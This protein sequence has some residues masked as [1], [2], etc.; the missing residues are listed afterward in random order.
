M[1]EA[2]K[3]GVFIWWNGTVKWNGEMEQWNGIVE[4]NGGIVE[5]PRPSSAFCDPLPFIKDKGLG[6]QDTTVF[7]NH[8]RPVVLA[9]LKEAEL[10]MILQE[11]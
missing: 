5:R 10:K 6:N 9:V 2:T 11:D 8:G 1:D 3:L 7:L 4:W